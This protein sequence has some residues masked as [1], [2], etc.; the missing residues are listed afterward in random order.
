[1]LVLALQDPLEQQRTLT[2]DTKHLSCLKG[3]G[4]GSHQASKLV[5]YNLWLVTLTATTG[6]YSICKLHTSLMILS[7]LDTE[8]TPEHVKGESPLPITTGEYIVCKLLT[9]LIILSDIETKITPR[10]FKDEIPLSIT[11]GE[12]IVCKL[13]NSLIIFSI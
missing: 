5:L 4:W 13:H 11:T 2:P 3:T 1:M 6:E 10:P 8:I 12:Y 9:S 7:D